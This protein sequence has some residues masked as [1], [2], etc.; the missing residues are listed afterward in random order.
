MKNTTSK[1][2]SDVIIQNCS[3]TN[4]SSANE[5]TR[6]AVCALADLTGQDVVGFDEALKGSPATIG[7]GISVGDLS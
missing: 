5:H 3:I 7:T 4:V 1:Q 2:K 6:A